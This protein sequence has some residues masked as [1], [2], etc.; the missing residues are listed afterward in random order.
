VISCEEV[1]FVEDEAIREKP[2][3]KQGVWGIVKFWEG[4]FMPVSP[5]GNTSGTVT[6]V[7]RKIYVFEKTHFSKVER[8]DYSGFYTKIYTDRIDSTVSNSKGFFELSLPPGEYSMFVKENSI[9]Y[10]NSGDGY[11]YISPFTIKKDSLSRVEF[12]I[13]YKATY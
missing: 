5:Y 1:T 7:E 6:P 3:I 8:V 2:T 4:D 11:G 9:Y 12:N 13:N 10:S